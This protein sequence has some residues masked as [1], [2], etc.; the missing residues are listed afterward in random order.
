MTDKNISITDLVSEMGLS[1]NDLIE[2]RQWLAE[3]YYADCKNS[4]QH[5]RLSDGMSLLQLA[6][7][8]N[9]SVDRLRQIESGHVPNPI[10]LVTL[11]T[12]LGVTEETIKEGIECRE[13]LWK[14]SV[15]E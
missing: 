4:I 8:T 1:D 9:L 3:S 14:K 2:A 7:E 13:N 11:A 12:V 10:E 15:I 6:Y 5:L